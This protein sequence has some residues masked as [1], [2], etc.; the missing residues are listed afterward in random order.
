MPTK[1]RNNL[2]QDINSSRQLKDKKDKPLPCELN[3]DQE[4][5]VTKVDG[6]SQRRNS[7]DDAGWEMA[8]G[9]HGGS[10]TK[11][12]RKGTRTVANNIQVTE[13]RSDSTESINDKIGNF[14]LIVKADNF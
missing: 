1:D 2:K 4:S 6:E 5:R 7:A 12:N 3:W 10:K 13:R 8:T 14:Y 11:R 9:T